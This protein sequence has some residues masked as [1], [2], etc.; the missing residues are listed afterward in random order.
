M[1][2]NKFLTLNT[3]NK[4]IYIYIQHTLSLVTWHGEVCPGFKS[5]ISPLTNKAHGKFTSTPSRWVHCKVTDGEY[6]IHKC[7]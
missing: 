7:G 1:K 2:N 4:I 5:T 3:T 6:G